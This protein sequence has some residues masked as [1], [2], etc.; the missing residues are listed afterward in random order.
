MKQRIQIIP[1]RVIRRRLQQESFYI[2]LATLGLYVRELHIRIFI[3]L[4][5][6]WYLLETR[7]YEGYR[8]KKEEHKEVYSNTNL[9]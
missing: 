3:V 8:Y 9:N 4:G 1:I 2:L 6:S 7:D 5:L